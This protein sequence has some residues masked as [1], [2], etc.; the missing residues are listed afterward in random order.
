MSVELVTQSRTHWV[1]REPST[2]GSRVRLI[3]EAIGYGVGRGRGQAG[4]LGPPSSLPPL[5]EEPTSKALSA[6]RQP[7]HSRPAAARPGTPSAGLA[8]LGA[9]LERFLRPTED[10]GIM[11]EA[12]RQE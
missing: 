6:C 8:G 10:P 4:I 5:L 1:G 11:L 12:P 9:D 7:S 3:G 2:A